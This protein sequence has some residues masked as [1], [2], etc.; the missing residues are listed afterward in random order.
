MKKITLFWFRR[1]LRLSDN[2][3]LNEA[4][5][6]CKANGSVLMPLFIFDSEILSELDKD[7]HRLSFIYAANES[8]NQ[9]LQDQESNLRTFQGTPILVFTELFKSY[10]IDAVFCNEDYE[11]YAR[12]RDQSIKVLCEKNHLFFHSF[13]DQVI[14]HKDEIVKADGS[15][16]V[17]YT[18]YKNQWLS[19]FEQLD[20]KVHN[21]LDYNVFL[22][23]PPKPMISLIDL[24]FERSNR[25]F[26]SS[27]LQLSVVDNYQNTRD[28]PSNENGTSHLGVHLRFGT[29]SIRQLILDIQTTKNHHTFLSELIWRE[30]FMQILWHYPHTVHQSFKPQYDRIQWR[31]N[32]DEFDRWKNG[33]TGYPI[34]DA[35][36]RE[37]NQTGYMH[38]RVRMICAS[39]LCKHLLIDWRWGEAY[40]AQ[41]LMDYELASNIGNWQWASGSGVD[42]APYFRIF[43]PHTQLKKFDPSLKYVQKWVSEYQSFDYPQELVE[44]K[45]ARERCLETYKSAL[46]R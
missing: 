41:K 3:A 8:I 4:V 20:I 34:V 19:A 7:D 17:V 39:F 12:E 9:K 18:P 14:F 27:E 25:K 31:N 33:T 13:K 5:K 35:G 1:D 36:M 26:P 15:P 21:T 6:H 29:I 23:E 2:T 22:K 11:P 32:R 37:L 38:N 44:H 16:Y 28:I 10:S 43:N 40:F 30:F 46:N 24:G 42:A 45:I